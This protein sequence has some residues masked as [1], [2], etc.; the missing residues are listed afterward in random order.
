M[1]CTALTV[2]SAYSR[3][4]TNRYEE[5]E[6]D[7]KYHVVVDHTRSGGRV[8]EHDVCGIHVRKY[9][10]HQKS[11]EEASKWITPASTVTITEIK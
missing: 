10:S 3:R 1:K 2:G 9:R 4:G 5:C 8:W 7:A 6:H 11:N